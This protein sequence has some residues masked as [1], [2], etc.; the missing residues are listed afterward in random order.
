MDY[1]GIDPAV[2]LECSHCKFI[3]RMPY[4][5]LLALVAETQQAQCVECERKMLHDWTT[6]AV[7]QGIISK[8]MQQANEAKYR[9][10]AQHG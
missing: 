7:V 3:S 9:R 8:R 6:V 5:E 1:V 2:G 10:I 4:S